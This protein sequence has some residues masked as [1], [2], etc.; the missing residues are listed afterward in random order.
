MFHSNLVHVARCADDLSPRPVFAKNI[1]RKMREWREPWLGNERSETLT[2]A[3]GRCR[4]RRFPAISLFRRFAPPQP[5]EITDP[6][7]S[8]D[9]LR[10]QREHYPWRIR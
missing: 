2:D 4:V 10:R 1:G 3:A 5:L 8:E 6:L 7:T 9:S